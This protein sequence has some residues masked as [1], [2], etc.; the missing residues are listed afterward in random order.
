MY[1]HLLIKAFEGHRHQLEALYTR[2]LKL[3]KV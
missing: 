1:L 3:N 2:K